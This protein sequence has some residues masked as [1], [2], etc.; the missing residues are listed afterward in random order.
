[1]K[2]RQPDLAA[3]G[4]LA[5]QFKVTLEHDEDGVAGLALAVDLVALGLEH[6]ERRSAE[7][8]EGLVGEAAEEADRSKLLHGRLLHGRGP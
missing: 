6:G 8:F 5:G 4:G 7:K 3:V 2:L 1:V